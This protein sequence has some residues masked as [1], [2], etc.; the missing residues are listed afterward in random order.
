MS[1][2]KRSVN[3]YE[4][5]EWKKTRDKK[6]WHKPNKAFKQAQRQ[7]ERALTNGTLRNAVANNKDFDGII[8]PDPKKHDEW[9]WN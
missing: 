8:I 2:T 5:K 3:D 6:R 4:D 7:S 1:K 9:D